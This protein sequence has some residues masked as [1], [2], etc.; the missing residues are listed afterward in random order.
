M[1]A[2]AEA[3]AAEPAARRQVRVAVVDDH[4]L[5]R[6]GVQ[7]ILEGEGDVLLVGQAGAID[8]ALP[9]LESAAA[10]V[11]L[12]D[13]RLGA[14]H[15][16]DLLSRLPAG[17]PPRVVIVTAFPDDQVIADAMRAGARG[18][19]LKDA[20]PDALLSAIRQVAAGGLSI[21]PELATRLVGALAQDGGAPGLS[22]LTSREREIA[23]LVG[24]GL[25]NRDIAQRLGVAEKTVKGHLTNIFYRLGVADRLE[26]ALLA[27]KL[28]L[29]PSPGEAR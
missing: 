18:V 9:M 26:L 7:R 11:L 29:A 19:V 5:F 8:D 23:A 13:L 6:E 24:R 10:D 17:G 3:T 16:L 4:P 12:L 27:I 22:H 20:A 28:R 14:A 2:S 25:R 21:P 1:S 15:G